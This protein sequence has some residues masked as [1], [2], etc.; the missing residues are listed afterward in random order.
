[1]ILRAQIPLGELR[2]DNGGPM[3]LFSV[4][5]PDVVTALSIDAPTVTHH[6]NGLAVSLPYFA[7]LLY[8]G[9]IMAHC[10]L[11]T[12]HYEGDHFDRVGLLND[13]L[14]RSL[15]K[16]EGS[17]YDQHLCLKHAEDIALRRRFELERKDWQYL[18]SLKYGNPSPPEK[19]ELPSI[20]INM[21]AYNDIIRTYYASHNGLR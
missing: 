8:E 10:A 18:D 3:L 15:M 2:T 4:Y 19:R 13:N 14:V 21:D 20:G 5:K 7:R 11:W 9:N 12:P 17:V 1:M 16:V 6:S